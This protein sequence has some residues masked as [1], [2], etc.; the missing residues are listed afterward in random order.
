VVPVTI[1]KKKEPGVL[2][3]VSLPGFKYGINN[4]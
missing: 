4:D 1:I 3:P 2:V